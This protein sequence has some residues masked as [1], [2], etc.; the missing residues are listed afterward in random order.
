MIVRIIASSI[1]VVVV[2]VATWGLLNWANSP[3]KRQ[4]VVSNSDASSNTTTQDVAT[5]YFATKLPNNYRVQ[6][7]D[8]PTDKAMVQ[9]TAFAK[10]GNGAQVGI[11]SALLPTSGLDGVADF[12][13]RI[14]R[15]DL[16]EQVA[17]VGFT[18]GTT[19][20]KKDGSELTTFITEGQRYASIAISGDTVDSDKVTALRTTVSTNWRWL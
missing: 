15:T 5:E 11:T 13:F 9:M 19:F 12:L 1:L 4:I 18:N 14:R 10:D 3:V 2:G 17:T 16:Y 8:N 20:R 6:T 7:D